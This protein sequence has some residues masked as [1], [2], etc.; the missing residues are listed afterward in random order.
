[1]NDFLKKLTS[2]KFILALVGALA[3]IAMALGADGAQITD[4]IEQVAG[5]ITTMGSIMSYIS[6]EAKVDAA[7][8]GKGDGA[9]G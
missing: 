6:A 4:I 9:N 5:I 2:R 8:A 7:R 1:M 3:G